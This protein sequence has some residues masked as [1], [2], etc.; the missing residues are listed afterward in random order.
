MSRTLVVALL[1]FLAVS[2]HAADT[3]STY[4]HPEP[5]FSVEYPS[6]WRAKLADTTTYEKAEGISLRSEARVTFVTEAT[7]GTAMA[8]VS[9]LVADVE[10]TAE[11]LRAVA[12]KVAEADAKAKPEDVDVAGRRW[13]RVE[14]KAGNRANVRAYCLAG[15][16]AFMVSLSVPADMLDGLRGTHRRMMATLKAQSL[17]EPGADEEADPASPGPSPGDVRGSTEGAPGTAVAMVETGSP[18][19]TVDGNG[20]CSW[21]GNFGCVSPPPRGGMDGTEYRLADLYEWPIDGAP[22]DRGRSVLHRMSRPPLLMQLLA[23]HLR[24]GEVFGHW[25][26]QFGYLLPTTV[27]PTGDVGTDVAGNRYFTFWLGEEQQ[28]NLW[29]CK[30]KGDGGLVACWPTPIGGGV[31]L[32]FGPGSAYTGDPGHRREWKGS[33]SGQVPVYVCDDPIIAVDGQAKLHILTQV[34]LNP[35]RRPSHQLIVFDGDSGRVDHVLPL[36]ID[37]KVLSFDVDP[38]GDYYLAGSREGGLGGRVLKMSSSGEQ[39]QWPAGDPA[40]PLASE[41]GSRGPIASVH[42]GLDGNVYVSEQTGEGTLIRSFTTDGH[43]VST[44]TFRGVFR[45]VTPLL[46]GLDRQTEWYGPDL[47]LCPEGTS[48]E[49]AFGGYPA[50]VTANGV[51]TVYPNIEFLTGP[52]GECRA[53]SRGNIYLS[54]TTWDRLSRFLIKIAKPNT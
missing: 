46:N 26:P 5:E 25:D 41:I 11:Q 14:W 42:I 3:W 43:L 48:V 47:S 50:R 53:D 51:T 28:N 44:F 32:S 8:S 7:Q 2:A 37:G 45:R 9:A 16:G 22:A 49:P 12:T 33:M 31:E 19:F 29:V 6:A 21:I 35:A 30:V 20:L 17:P 39:L 10:I 34:R 54:M 18:L 27:T 13:V 52:V 23:T 36:L 24:S 38:A 1:A 4:S 40:S 15:P